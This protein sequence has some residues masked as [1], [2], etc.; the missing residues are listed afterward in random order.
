[1]DLSYVANLAE[2]FGTVA[3]V[4]SLIYVA[5]QIRQNTRATRLSTAQNVFHD[6][7]ESTATIANDMELAEIHLKGMA[8][9][10]SLTPIERYR[11]YTYSNYA[12]RGYENAYYQNQEGALD[13]HV[14]EG[15]VANMLLGKDTSGYQ[16]FWRDRKQIFSEKFQAFYDNELP[17]PEFDTLD[18]YRATEED[19]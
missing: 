18:I 15:V 8:S 5:V 12:F 4:V 16:A 6:L 7:R 9:A 2:I 1:M 13:A 11:F 10:E 14:W 19:E 3:I 17:A